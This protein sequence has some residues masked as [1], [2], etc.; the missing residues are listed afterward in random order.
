MSLIQ[1]T[2]LKYKQITWNWKFIYF[3]K[4]IGSRVSQIVKTLGVMIIFDSLLN[5]AIF[6]CCGMELAVSLTKDVSNQKPKTKS[7]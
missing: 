7:I 6:I 4:N 3:N 2:F 5:L 1:N